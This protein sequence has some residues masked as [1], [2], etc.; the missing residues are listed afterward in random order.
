[1]ENNDKVITIEDV[2]KLVD[3]K[4]LDPKIDPQDLYRQV[5]K[6]TANYSKEMW[7]FLW[8]PLLLAVISL[9][10]MA[11]LSENN[12]TKVWHRL[13]IVGFLSSSLWGI[14]LLRKF[15]KSWWWVPI[16]CVVIIY[17]IFA[18][19]LSIKDLISYIT[20]LL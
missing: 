6:V 18:E 7:I 12:E 15:E 10:G 14:Y 2:H 11:F 8:M 3:A 20:S 13:S 1:M 9:L 17:L 16:L 19:A 4:N 5:D